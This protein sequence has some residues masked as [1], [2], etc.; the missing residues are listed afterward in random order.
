MHRF[1]QWE[2][3]YR[4]AKYTFYLKKNTSASAFMSPRNPYLLLYILSEYVLTDK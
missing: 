1:L 4:A 3:N 2:G